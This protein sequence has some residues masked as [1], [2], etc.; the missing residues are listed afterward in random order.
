MPP[1]Y[2]PFPVIFVPSILPSCHSPCHLSTYNHSPWEGK[3]FAY[4]F[5]MH[6]AR[7]SSRVGKTFVI[8]SFRNDVA[9][10]GKREKVKASLEVTNEDR[11]A[12]ICIPLIISPKIFIF[13]LETRCVQTFIKN[14]NKFDMLITELRIW[15][16]ILSIFWGSF[17]DTM[18]AQEGSTGESE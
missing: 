7:T 9:S 6:T 18:E 4:I 2:F 16:S 11:Q 12:Y 1:S 5:C 17:D 14:L 3:G 15:M 13:H 8:S 10:G